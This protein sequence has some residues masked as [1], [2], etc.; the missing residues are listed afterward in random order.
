MDL[1]AAEDPNR[2]FGDRDIAGHFRAGCCR[3]IRSVPLDEA[4][5]MKY[6]S[7]T[8]GPRPTGFVPCRNGTAAGR[9]AMPDTNTTLHFTRFAKV[10]L[11]KEF[12]K[13]TAAMVP[14]IVVD[15][16]DTKSFHPGVR[17]IS[18]RA[19]GVFRLLETMLEAGG[20]KK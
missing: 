11:Q 10:V 20:G 3:A 14:H 9:S 16:I 4:R 1:E 2:R 15:E 18:R 5:L 8:S 17:K 12:G 6:S 7:R 19:R 13:G